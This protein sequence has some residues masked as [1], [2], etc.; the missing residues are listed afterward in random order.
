MLSKRTAGMFAVVFV[1]LVLGCSGDKSTGKKADDKKGDEDTGDGSKLGK[2]TGTVK[3]DGKP[4]PVGTINFIPE[5]GK[6]VPAEIEDGKYTAIGVPSGKVTVTVDTLPAKKEIGNLEE[7]LKKGLPKPPQ[8]VPAPPDMENMVK[9]MKERLEKLKKMV[10]VP[11]V[12]AD[13]KTS[14]LSLT[15]EPGAKEFNIDLKKP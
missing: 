7:T 2:V 6:P 3:Y 14:G 1:F 11:A 12:Y 10:E 8:G 5:K 13:A 9:M 4:L 15:V